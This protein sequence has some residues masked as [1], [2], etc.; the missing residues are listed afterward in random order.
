MPTKP[1][2]PREKLIPRMSQRVYFTSCEEFDFRL[3]FA[4]AYVRG[5]GAEVGECFSAVQQVGDFDFDGWHRGWLRLAQTVH[6]QADADR[7]AGNG[8]S[9][10]SGYQRASNYLYWAGFF[11]L[12]GSAEFLD[13]HH[14][15]TTA[16]EAAAGLPGP[17]F[18]RILIPYEGDTLPGWFFPARTGARARTLIVMTGTDATNEQLYYFAGGPTAALRDWNVLCFSGPGQLSTISVRP[19]LAFRPDYENVLPAVVDHALTMPEVDPDGLALMGFSKGGYLA[20]RGAAD[21]PRIKALIANSPITNFH[22]VIWPGVQRMLDHGGR[23]GEW[24]A[25]LLQWIYGAPSMDAVRQAMRE[26]N[27]DGAVERI[28]CPTLV[29][30]SEGEGERFSTQTE[31]F[32]ERLRAPYERHHFTKEQGADAHCQINNWTLM[33]QVVFDWLDRAVPG[34]AR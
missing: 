14:R 32:V 24:A 2:L 20:P 9:A 1:D 17:E 16:F 4:L 6:A 34:S 10:R 29:L 23:M 30:D 15:S 7:K 22:D 12:P 13:L 31:E 18:R 21:E 26:Y 5:G 33:H 19:G 28:A 27:L 3:L 11:L 8:H 25:A